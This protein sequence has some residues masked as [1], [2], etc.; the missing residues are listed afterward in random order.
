[1]RMTGAREPW[2]AETARRRHL[3]R[4]MKATGRLPHSVRGFLS[5]TVGK[6]IGLIVTSTKAENRE[7]TYSVEA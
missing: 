7:R 4:L 3:E 1:M 6:K 2:P 5:G